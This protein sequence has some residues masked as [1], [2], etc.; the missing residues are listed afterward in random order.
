MSSAIDTLVSHHLW[1][2][3]AAVAGPV[4]LALWVIVGGILLEARHGDEITARRP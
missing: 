3:V 1:W 4:V 2:A